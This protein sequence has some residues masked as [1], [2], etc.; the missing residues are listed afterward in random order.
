MINTSFIFVRHGQSQ[1]NADVVIAD[2]NSHLTEKGIQQARN[3]ANEIR[4]LNIEHIICSPYIRAQQTAETIA[5]ELGIEISH[6]KVFDDL[7][8][9]GLGILENKPREHEGI[10]YFLND[11]VQNIEKS[12]D[13]FYRMSKCLDFLKNESLNGISFGR[14]CFGDFA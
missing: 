9:R 8:E 11:D 7:K 2:A 12:E 3:T 1:A 10:W 13:L 6:I 5:G 4:S 14:S